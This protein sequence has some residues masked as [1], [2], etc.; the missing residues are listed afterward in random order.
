MSEDGFSIED[1]KK[2]PEHLENAKQFRDTVTDHL[3]KNFPDVDGE[4]RVNPMDIDRDAFPEAQELADRIDIESATTSR[5]S[6]ELRGNNKNRLQSALKAADEIASQM[7]GTTEVEGSIT[8]NTKLPVFVTK[9]NP[10]G[11]LDSSSL[12]TG[13]IYKFES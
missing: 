6:L 2:D 10:E 5:V 8:E 4:V 11:Y 13:S 9:E 12:R 7:H 1:L 3:N